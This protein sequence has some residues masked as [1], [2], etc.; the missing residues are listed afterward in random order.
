MDWRHLGVDPHENFLP[1]QWDDVTEQV[2]Q[3][4]VFGMH[5]V[6]ELRAIQV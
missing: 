3:D 6:Y 5:T 2:F 4:I 1:V